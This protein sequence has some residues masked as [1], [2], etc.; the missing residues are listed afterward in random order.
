M[1]ETGCDM[2][3]GTRYLPGG[4]VYGVGLNRKMTSRVAN[5]LAATL[6]NSVASDLTGSFRIYRK[7]VISKIMPLV[8]SRGN[9]FQMKIFTRAQYLGNEIEEVPITFPDRI[10][11]E[12]KLG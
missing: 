3:S 5:F 9:V 12:S 1:E 10:F 4:S 8:K 11:G 7:D 2:V 6:L